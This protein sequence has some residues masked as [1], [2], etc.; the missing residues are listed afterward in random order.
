MKRKVGQFQARSD[1]GRV[2][3]IYEWQEVV[4]VGTLAAPQ[5]TLTGLKE[6]RTAEG[7]AVNSKG[8]GEYEIVALGLSVRLLAS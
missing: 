7:I 5:D 1:D 6:L 2:F 3:T 4:A 8:K